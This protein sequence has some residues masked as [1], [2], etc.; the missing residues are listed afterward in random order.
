[1]CRGKYLNGPGYRNQRS[2][3]DF[4]PHADTRHIVVGGGE[5]RDP[6]YLE[7]WW[8]CTLSLL[9]VSM[10][11]L[12]LQ[13]T[14]YHKAEILQGSPQLIAQEIAFNI[15]FSN[16]KLH[17]NLDDYTFVAIHLHY[18]FNICEL[19]VDFLTK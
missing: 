7:S 9:S 18:F 14:Q 16:Q 12:R 19:P 5:S 15:C 2:G 11:W 3:I 6:R 10:S 13:R 17:R 4:S 1:M 8:L